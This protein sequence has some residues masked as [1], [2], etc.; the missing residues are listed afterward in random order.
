MPDLPP[1]TIVTPSFNQGL[2]IEHTI[3]SVLSQDY[4][5]IEYLVID[6]GS[7]DETLQVLRRYEDRL[8]WTSEPDRGQSHALNK[9]FQRAK[10]E[11]LAWLNSDDVY[12][13]GAITDSVTF[14][15]EHPDVDLVY[16]DIQFI[17]EHG[18]ILAEEIRSRPFSL[19]TLLTQFGSIQQ[20]SAFFRRRLL[21]KIGGINENLHY[22]MDTE[23]WIR[24]ALHGKGHYYPGVRAQSR[25]HSAAK[26]MAFQP[27]FWAE[28]RQVLD[29]LFAQ[30]ELPEKVHRIRR[31][32]YAHC[33]LYWGDHLIQ[34]GDRTQ[35][36]PHLWYAA[37]T[38]PRPR[39]RLIALLLLIDS[40]LGT[41]LAA[42]ARGLRNRIEG[43]PHP[44]E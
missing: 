19:T 16:G 36:R 28:H 24:I 10:G 42:A 14:L 11:I 9:G 6:G 25:V 12:L 39:R 34:A 44:W 37:R 41:G 1:V 43:H 8:S 13:P 38:H 7:T 27:R 18:N 22:V 4:P 21:E 23:L 32:A 33:E 29:A 20:Q 35:A 5:D 26:S 31:E 15:Q 17:D 40:W 3:Q 2:F 30:K